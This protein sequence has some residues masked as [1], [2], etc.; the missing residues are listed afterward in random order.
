M[1]RLHIA[2]DVEGVLADSHLAT[3]RKSDVLDEDEVPPHQYDFG[4]DGL[5]DEYMHVSQNVW[6]N[7]NHLIPPMEDGLWK[8]TRQLARHHTVDIVTSRTG[9]DQQ[10]KEWLDGYN[11]AYDDFIATNRPRSNKTDYGDHDVH[12]DDAPHVVKHARL[13]DRFVFLVDRPYNG[14]LRDDQHSAIQ[15]VSGVT[16]ASELLR[17]PEYVQ[18]VIPP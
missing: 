14:S 13:D 3:A 15:R 17:D 6:H 1:R 4:D 11:I 10:V 18:E 5:L 7:H 2:L 16:Q 8:A 9:V 12:I